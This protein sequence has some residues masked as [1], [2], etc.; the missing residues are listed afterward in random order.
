[1]R[2][3]ADLLR[4]VACMRAEGVANY[5]YPTGNTTNFNGTGVDPQ[6]P[7]VVKISIKCGNK[8]GLPLWWSAGW[9]AP[10]EVSVQPSVPPGARPPGPAVAAT[11][12]PAG[13]GSPG[14][15]AL[16][17]NSGSGGDG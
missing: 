13:S 12:V 2:S 7:S 11:G 8:L 17:G 3:Q 14:A 4:Y 16:R 5:P 10:G 15:S 9:G 1:M 6:S